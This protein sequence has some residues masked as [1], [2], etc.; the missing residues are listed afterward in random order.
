VFIPYKASVTSISQLDR[1]F[2]AYLYGSF[3]I[4]RFY[5]NDRMFNTS[6]QVGVLGPVVF[7]KEV[8]DFIHNIHIL[9]MVMD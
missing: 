9:E 1:P 7:E 4:H 2:A 5:K 6:L 8:Q 3:G